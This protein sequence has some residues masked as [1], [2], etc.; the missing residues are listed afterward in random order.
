MRRAAI[1]DAQRSRP[2][3]HDVTRSEP[4]TTAQKAIDPPTTTTHT[5]SIARSV[6]VAG[7]RVRSTTITPNGNNQ[8]TNVVATP[9]ATS[10]DQNVGAGI[11]ASRAIE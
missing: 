10:A 9:Y 4:S 8:V 11:A 5:A 1:A 3:I 2:T 7:R 6:V